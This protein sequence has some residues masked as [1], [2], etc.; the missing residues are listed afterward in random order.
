MKALAT[1]L[2]MATPAVIGI[3]LMAWIAA[4]AVNHLF[5]WFELTKIDQAAAFISC[6]LIGFAVLVYTLALGSRVRMSAVR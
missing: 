6:L 2:L 1:K 5:P 3:A 4:S